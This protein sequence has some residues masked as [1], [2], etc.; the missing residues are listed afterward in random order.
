MVVNN[1]SLA[2]GAKDT[3]YAKNFSDP[4]GNPKGYEVGLY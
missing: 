2:H 1:C 4:S 3:S